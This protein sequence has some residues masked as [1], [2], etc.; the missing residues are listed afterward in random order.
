MTNK[1]TT[2]QLRKIVKAKSEKCIKMLDEIIETQE[3]E[4]EQEQEKIA[5]NIICDKL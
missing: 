5:D 1:L 3:Q 2:K 4:Q